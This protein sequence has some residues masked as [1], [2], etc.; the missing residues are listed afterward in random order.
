MKTPSLEITDRLYNQETTLHLVKFSNKNLAHLSGEISSLFKSLGDQKEL[1]VWPSIIVA[2]KKTRFELASLPLPPERI[3]TDQLIKQLNNDLQICH[4]SFPDNVEQLSNIVEMLKQFQGEEN[5]F[6]SW[7]QTECK[8]TD[9]NDCLCLLYSKHINLIEHLINTDKI[10]SRRNLTVTSPRGLKEF[11]FFS[12]IFFCGSIGL[13]SENQ[14]RNFEYVWRTPRAKNLYFLSYDW[15]REDFD[16][17]PTFAIEPNKISVSIR[18]INIDDP[19]LAEVINIPQDEEVKIDVGDIDFFPVALFSPESSATGTGHYEYICEIRLLALED[20]TVIYKDIESSSRIVELN[21][22]VEIKK[23]L[24]KNLVPGMFLIVRTEGSGDSIAAVA[25]LLLGDKADQIRDI[26][27][28]WKT[29]FR[30]KLSTYSSVYEVA[31]ILTNLG[32][33]TANETNVKN[34]QR[35]DTIKPNNKD[36]FEAIMLY[37]EIPDLSEDYWENARKINQMHIKAGKEISKLLLSRINDSNKR[38]L[39]KY[40]RIDVK[41]KGLSG[42]VSVINIESISPETYKVPSSQLNKVLHIEKGL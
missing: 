6:L 26:Q 15:I 36:D 20:G 22:Q 31:R 1:S 23:V 11:I 29:A 12:R 3:I 39:E 2:L 28:Q 18:T 10:L 34:W 19:Q 27:E 16:P 14:F 8:K 9:G 24:N 30:N 13:F 33:P 32:A 41:I 7:I 42:K 25:D 35:H 40:G 37:A 5:Q 21:D 4:V 17:R 38:D